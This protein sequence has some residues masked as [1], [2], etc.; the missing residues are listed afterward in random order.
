M[1]C[2]P[3]TL[4]FFKSL[5]M[6]RA[7]AAREDLVYNLARLLKTLREEIFD[8]PHRRWKPRTPAMLLA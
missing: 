1:P 3:K 5:E 8:D 6:Y 7:S 4:A 2:G